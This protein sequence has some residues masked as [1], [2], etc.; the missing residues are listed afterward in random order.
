M[1]NASNIDSCLDNEIIVGDDVSDSSRDPTWVVGRDRDGR[2]L[3][4]SLIS[5]S[6]FAVL[7]FTSFKA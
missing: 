7:L 4:S 3:A 6:L 5:A 1:I 2:Q